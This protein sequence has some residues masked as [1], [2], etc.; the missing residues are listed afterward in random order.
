MKN[1]LV[2]DSWV[3]ARPQ[4]H[5][6]KDQV[7]FTNDSSSVQLPLNSRAVVR[8]SVDQCRIREARVV[9]SGW[10]FSSETLEPVKRVYLAQGG[11]LIGV[12]KPSLR[13]DVRRKLNLVYDYTG[14]VF[15]AKLAYPAY[16][17]DLFTVLYATGAGLSRIDRSCESA[18]K[19][20]I[21]GAKRFK[22]AGDR[23]EFAT[24]DLADPSRPR[25]EAFPLSNAFRIHVDRAQVVNGKA[26]IR[27]WCFNSQN[28][29]SRL[30][31]GLAQGDDVVVGPAPCGVARDDVA[32][33][34]ELGP[35]THFCGFSLSFDYQSPRPDQ[36]A[37]FRL[38]AVD[39]T[40]SHSVASFV[41][42]G[43]AAG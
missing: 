33:K 38:F 41:Q 32:K 16:N 25:A 8:A 30:I 35:R 36:R 37:P 13:V 15:D 42:V 1:L 24:P 2:I 39:E 27:G 43:F 10:A 23:A 4:L 14:Y 18:L 31:V 26:N 34:L 6:E 3:Q 22:V 29:A 21:D 19:P 40:P 5:I 17:E 7:V 11:S 20:R 28:Q 12:A 9:C